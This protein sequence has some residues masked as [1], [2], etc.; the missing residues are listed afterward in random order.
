MRR[1]EFEEVIGEKRRPAMSGDQAA[2]FVAC[3][4]VASMRSNLVY[5]GSDSDYTLTAVRF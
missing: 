2:L 1:F 4:R 3:G 5:S